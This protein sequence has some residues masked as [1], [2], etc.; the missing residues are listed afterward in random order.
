MCLNRDYR[1]SLREIHSW[2]LRIVDLII[3][4]FCGR[5]KPRLQERCPPARTRSGFQPVQAGFVLVAAILIA[6]FYSGCD[7]GFEL[8]EGW[9]D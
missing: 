3:S 1:H 5:L 2:Q 9:R 7:R 4:R 6:G 8:I